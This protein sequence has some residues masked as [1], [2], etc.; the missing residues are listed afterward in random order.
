MKN[1]NLLLLVFILL[2]ASSCQNIVYLVAGFKT[3]RIESKETV[4]RFLQRNH[5][6]T[7]DTYCLDSSIFL[8]L[9][10]QS[11]KPGWKPGFRPIQ[12]RVYD[13]NG[14]PI[15]HW[16]SCEGYLKSLKTFDTV[17]PRNQIN[18]DSTLSLQDDLKRYYTLDGQKAHINCGKGVDYY[19]IAYFSKSTYRM[20]KYSLKTIEKY[21]KKH[22]DLRIKLYK[23]NV[24]VMQWWNTELIVDSRKHD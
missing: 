4:M 16:A 15:M 24:D 14:L 20:S 13:S 22:P 18:L 19:I 23:I 11:F 3:P 2:V 8:G 6:D 9:M 10:H 1:S 5:Q 17:P 21:V 12:I 7:S